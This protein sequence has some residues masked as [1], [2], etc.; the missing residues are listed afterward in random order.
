MS[1]QRYISS[2]FWSDDWVDSLS[3]KEKL[4]YMHL[5]TNERTNIAGIYRITI[6]RIKDDTGIERE[7][8]V[9]ALDKFAS[10]KKAF[11]YKEY[12]IIPKWPRHQRIGERGKLRLAIIAIIR[13]LPDE[14]KLYISQPGNYEFDLSFLNA[15]G[16]NSPADSL[17]IDYP[18]KGQNDDSLS[19]GYPESG[20]N[21]DSLSENDGG[22]PIDYPEK[23]Q[24]GDRR[25]SDSDSDL[26][27]NIKSLRSYTYSDSEKAFIRIWQQNM[28]IFNSVSR[29]EKPKEW[30][31][32]WENCPYPPGD[33]KRRMR[34]F[35]DGVK[36]G[37]IEKR[38]V[39]ATPDRFVLRGH[40]NTSDEQ[41]KKPGNRGGVSPPPNLAGK[42][43][44]GGLET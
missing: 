34:N 11:Y 28:D 39:P 6:K 3:V 31:A 37:A 42:K 43:S 35:I 5:L 27:I 44:L 21:G 22:L 14:I 24:N 32:F 38:F 9:A 26:D 36:S 23:G 12:I 2:S 29:I 33:I 17:S 7:E 4:I 40:L 19:I 41:Y 8:I 10:A 25:R 16:K 13:S 15:G 30:A 20:Q 18:E 1:T